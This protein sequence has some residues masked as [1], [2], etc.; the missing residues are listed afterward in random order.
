L[1]EAFLCA[2]STRE[3]V[4]DAGAFP[5]SI[6]AFSAGLNINIET[7]V[8][9]LVGENGSGKSTLLE[10]IA[11]ACGFPLQ[12][13]ARDHSHTNKEQGAPLADALRLAWRRKIGTGFFFRAESFFNFARYIDGV[14]DQERYGGDA[15][16]HAQSHGESFLALFRNRFREGLFLL[17]E[18][19]AAL[20][21]QR[22]LAFLRI[23]H[24]LERERR[25]QFIIATHSPI[26]LHYPGATILSLDGERVVQ[27]TPEQTDQVQLTREFLADPERTLRAILLD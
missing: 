23:L 6:P 20:S 15:R 18:P 26:L 12:G 24:D 9:F 22:Q 7:K 1:D 5:F 13:G 10:G 27:V 14:G 19:E 8:T 17:D 16:F 2:I 25:S 4:G 11:S 21:P 3:G